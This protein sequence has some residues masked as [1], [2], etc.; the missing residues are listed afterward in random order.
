MI[1][2]LANDAQVDR[3]LQALKTDLAYRQQLAKRIAT[4]D[5]IKYDSAMRRLQRYITEGEQKRDITSRQAAPYRKELKQEGRALPPP[6]AIIKPPVFTP[7]GFERKG[8]EDYDE[9]E[10]DEDEDEDE[11]TAGPYDN[12][13]VQNQ[14]L[15]SVIAYHDG[16]IRETAKALDLSRRAAAQLDA[17][18]ASYEADASLDIMQS[19]DAVELEFAV[20][21]FLNSIDADDRRDIEA[22]HDGLLQGEM[23]D[24][25]IG[26]IIRDIQEERTTFD[27]WVDAAMH[28]L[29][30]PEDTS[31]FWAL[32]REAYKRQK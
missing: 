12:Y 30:Y 8:F 20:R 26:V 13:P 1:K 18:V 6:A 11:E 24:W 31:E 9:D 14:D 27:D 16:D 15:L 10:G 28:D 5:G 4:R 29:E 19:V 22:F 21:D 7:S 17:L 32:W 23:A 25:R 2:R 3:L